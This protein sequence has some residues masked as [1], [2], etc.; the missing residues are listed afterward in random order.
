M[1]KAF[2][3][4][5][6]LWSLFSFAQQ[7]NEYEFV[8]VPTKFDFQKSENEYRLNTLLKYRLEEF[9]FNAF[10]TSDQMNSN[11]SD[12][13]LYLNA[14]VVNESTMFLTKLY[15]VFKN[16]DN[17]I[18]FQSDHGTSKIKERKESY[19]EALEE[20]LLSVKAVNYKF[21]GKANTRLT[22]NEQHATSIVAQPTEVINENSLFAQPI[23]NGYQLVDT[24]PKV[25]L[26]IFRT[27]QAD[28][29]TASSDTKNGVVFK[30][31]KVWIFEYYK[32]DQL[33]SEQLSIKF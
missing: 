7:V 5:F 9:G 25:I 20:A 21:T 13:C 12:R 15:V 27:S 16:C 14:N 23:A 10:Y 17:A 3:I 19:K 1:K 4:V 2:L 30:K 22:N 26:K 6:S 24:T 8:I 11:F 32:D 33:I 18:V 29:F 28:Y 31:N